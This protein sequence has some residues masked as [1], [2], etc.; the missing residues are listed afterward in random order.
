MPDL[1]EAYDSGARLSVNVAGGWRVISSMVEYDGGIAFADLFWSEPSYSGHPFHIVEGKITGEGPWKV[2]DTEIRR[3][4]QKDGST[5]PDDWNR[6]M[7]WLLRKK[8]TRD[9]DRLLGH[10]PL[11]EFIEEMT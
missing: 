5:A 10:H 8:I 4:R 6:Y 7:D 1:M 3:I 2:G 9:E 11:R